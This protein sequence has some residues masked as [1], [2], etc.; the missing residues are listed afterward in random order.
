MI[1]TQFVNDDRSSQEIYLMTFCGYDSYDRIF[2]RGGSLK[3]WDYI[4]SKFN[5]LICSIFSDFVNFLQT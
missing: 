3:G 2:N 1:K 5:K 4:Y